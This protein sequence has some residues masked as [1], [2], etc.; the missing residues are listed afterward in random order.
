MNNPLTMAALSCRNLRQTCSST[1]G[2]R[3]P[4]PPRRALHRSRR[5]RQ[6]LVRRRRRGVRVCRPSSAGCSSSS[7]C[8]PHTPGRRSRQRWSQARIRHERPRPEYA[9][10]GGG[11]YRTWPTSTGTEPPCWS[12]ARTA[13]SAGTSSCAS[14]TEH[15]FRW[16]SRS[17]ATIFGMIIGVLMGSVAGCSAA[18]STRSSRVTEVVMAFPVLLFI[19]ALA[20]TVGDRLNH[21]TFG[22]LQPGV[23]TLTIVIGVFGWYYPGKDYRGGGAVPPGEDFVEA[24]RRARRE[25]RTH[26][27]LASAAAPGRADHRTRRRRSSAPEAGHSSTT[28]VWRLR[29]RRSSRPGSSA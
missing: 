25:R 22:F 12:W 29:S 6:R 16:R 8:W 19:I 7:C 18:G 17:W 28:H 14:S 20:S 10:A 27:P 15:G 5:Q 3:P 26:H 11:H 21:V 23:F 1:R 13:S 4:R 9:A 24:A 2:L